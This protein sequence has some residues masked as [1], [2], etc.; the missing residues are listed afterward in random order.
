[1]NSNDAINDY[2]YTVIL[3]FFKHFQYFQFLDCINICSNEKKTFNEH[4]VVKITI[5]L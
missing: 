3:I 1:M 2:E 4:F 5:F